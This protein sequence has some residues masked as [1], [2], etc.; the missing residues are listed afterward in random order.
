MEG[1][2]RLGRTG[3]ALR[4]VLIAALVF[5]LSGCVEIFQYITQ[6]Q[7]GEIEV[8]ASVRVQKSLFE[9]ATGFTGEPPPDYESEFGFTEDE[10]LR[11]YP[12]QLEMGFRSIDTELE[13]GF[14][15]TLSGAPELLQQH[16]GAPFIP[17]TEREVTSI[18]F[19]GEGNGSADDDLALALFASSKY[20]LLISKN[21]L[22]N[23]SEVW[24]ETRGDRAPVELHDYE[25]VYL[26]EF[27][28]VYLF[29]S[30]ADG[31]LKIAH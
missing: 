27:P 29:A 9:I 30:D 12:E 25:D 17:H 14:E 11:E 19:E 18:L 24:Y 1:K 6:N 3:V 2:R 16:R 28:I 5:A 22:P 4:A 13:Y 7:D 21:Y 26:V 8:S 20:R 23:I 10:I 31:S 15:V